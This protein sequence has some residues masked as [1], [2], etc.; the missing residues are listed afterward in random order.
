MSRYDDGMKPS[1]WEGPVRFLSNYWWVLLLVVTALVVGII[2]RG[3]G[4]L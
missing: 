4:L 2:T 3:F 1:W